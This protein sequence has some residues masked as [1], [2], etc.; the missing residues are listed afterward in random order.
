MTKK[1]DDHAETAMIERPMKKDALLN[2]EWSGA[3]VDSLAALLKDAKHTFSK[4]AC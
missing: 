2:V 4:P 3:K 1:V